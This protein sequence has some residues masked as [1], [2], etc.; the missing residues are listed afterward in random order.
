MVRIQGAIGVV[1]A[2]A[3]IAASGCDTISC[4]P[5]AE[6]RSSIVWDRSAGQPGQIRGR[7]V[8]L[9]DGQPLTRSETRLTPVDSTWRSTRAGEFRYSRSRTAAGGNL[10]VR[11]PGYA[12]AVSAVSVPSDSSVVVVA[13][14]SRAQSVRGAACVN[15]TPDATPDQR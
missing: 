3:T 14:L 5:P 9:A 11:A 13:V 15:V 8:A 12:S 4:P 6:A 2:V 1:L 7:V 10:E